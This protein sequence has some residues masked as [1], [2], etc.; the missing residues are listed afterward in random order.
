MEPI[1]D[2]LSGIRT[3]TWPFDEQPSE[4]PLDE[5]FQVADL[6]NEALIAFR[7]NN[8][9]REFRQ[10]HQLA[11]LAGDLPPVAGFV[12]NVA[13]RY[14]SRQMSQRSVELLTT[15]VGFPDPPV[16]ALLALA[17]EHKFDHN[18]QEAI[19][20]LEKVVD[21]SPERSGP[22]RLLI[23]ML[24]QTADYTRAEFHLRELI[25]LNPENPYLR[26]D[27]VQ[28]LHRQNKMAEA[29]AA[30]DDFREAW[31]GSGSK[32][33]WSYLRTK[34]LGPYVDNMTQE[35]P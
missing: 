31:D 12:M 7:Q 19:G 21:R 2:F 35:S 15:L 34:G 27:L 6:I 22:R 16:A 32:A 33:V 23:D 5:L 14:R 18:D 30:L 29:R 26:I 25:E 24:Q 20:L 11:G 8:F 13:S 10:V 28:A 3:R 1:H 4:R 9:E 17:Q